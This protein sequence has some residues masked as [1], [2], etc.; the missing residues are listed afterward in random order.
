MVSTLLLV[1]TAFELGFL[2]RSFHQLLSECDGQI[3]VCG[4]GPVLSGVVTS[5]LLYTLSPKRVF[6][7]G[8]AGCFGSEIAL[9]STLEFNEVVCYGVGVGSGK[10]YRSV[11]DMGWAQY[12]SESE[13]IE[14]RD[15][16]P[17]SVESGSNKVQLLT[18]CSVSAD[19]I[20]AEVRQQKFPHAKAEDMEGFAVAAACML[21][22]IP[23]R[24][25]RG[26]SNRVGDRDKSQWR[27]RDAMAAVET[28]LVRVL[29]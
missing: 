14:I 21:A 11:T 17:L 15:T 26:I 18:C 5:R 10:D 29:K 20:D 7:I 24:I 6:L 25:L 23:L 2:S 13:R 3:Q 19:E 22:N 27:V 8:I 1:P 4:F 16:V 12:Q 28:E 9:G